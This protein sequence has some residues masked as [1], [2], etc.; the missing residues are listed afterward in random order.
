MQKSFAVGGF[1][2]VNSERLWSEHKKGQ[3]VQGRQRCSVAGPQ[4]PAILSLVTNTI[5]LG[6]RSSQIKE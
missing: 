6:M 2:H 1:S 3:A 4:R 5:W